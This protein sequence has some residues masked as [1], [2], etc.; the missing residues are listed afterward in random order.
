MVADQKYFSSIFFQSIF[1]GQSNILFIPA[2]LSAN[3]QPGVL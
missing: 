1:S 3:Y 2:M